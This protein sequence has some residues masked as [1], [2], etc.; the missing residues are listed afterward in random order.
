MSEY[1]ELRKDLF[2]SGYCVDPDDFPAGTDPE[3]FSAIDEGQATAR[4]LI[5][6]KKACET[7]L[8]FDNCSSQSEEIAVELWRRGVGLAV[9]GGEQFAV[10]TSASTS[11]VE[12]P[13]TFTFDL[14]KIPKEPTLA[15]PILRQGWRAG[16]LLVTGAPPQGVKAVRERYLEQLKVAN[17]T[18]FTQ[19]QETLGEEETDRT[20]QFIATAVF[21]QKDFRDFSAKKRKSDKSAK[22]RYDADSFDLEESAELM[23]LFLRETIAIRELGITRPANKAT[24][25]AAD[26]YQKLVTRYKTDAVTWADFNNILTNNRRDPVAALE[27]NSA[28]VVRVREK[29]PGASESYVRAAAR[30]RNGTPSQKAVV[31][32]LVGRYGKT[33]NISTGIIKAVAT[34]TAENAVK[35]I[36]GIVERAEAMRQIFGADHSIIRDGDFMQFARNYRTMQSCLDALTQFVQ[37]VHALSDEY[38]GNPD[39]NYAL[40]RRFSQGSPSAPREA[41]EAYLAALAELRAQGDDSLSDAQLRSA[42][43]QG[44]RSYSEAQKLQQIRLMKDRFKKRISRTGERAVAG[45]VIKHI[46]TL[47]PIDEIEGTT[48]AAYKMINAGYL[49]E[50]RGEAPNL[51]GEVDE[52]LRKIF[53]PQREYVTFTGALGQL[54][55][56]ERIAFATHHGL[57]PLMYGVEVSHETALFMLS[58]PGTLAEYYDS[59][60]GPKCQQLNTENPTDTALAFSVIQEDLRSFKQ[61]GAPTES[62]E[63]EYTSLR[64]IRDATL[65]VGGHALYLYDPGIARSPEDSITDQWLKSKVASI[66][67]P[68]EQAAALVRA[69]EALQSGTIVMAG[70]G[71]DNYRVVFSKAITHSDATD[72]ERAVIANSLGLDRLIFNAD[73]TQALHH[74]L[75][76]QVLTVTIHRHHQPEIVELSDDELAGRAAMELQP[77]I[78]QEWT[79]ITHDPLAFVTD[80]GL[81]I[82]LHDALSADNRSTIAEALLVA[83]SRYMEHPNHRTEVQGYE[84]QVYLAWQCIRGQDPQAAI[85]QFN[86]RP[87]DVSTS[88]QQGMQMIIEIIERI[89]Q[90]QLRPIL[91]LLAPPKPDK[92]TPTRETKQRRPQTGSAT[93]RTT[94]KP[95]T[96]TESTKLAAEHDEPTPENKSKDTE[97]S[98][99]IDALGHYLRRIGKVPL[100]T[101]IEEV[102]LAQTIEAGVFAWERL[103]AGD[104]SLGTREEL[105]KLVRNGS[106]AK[107][108]MIESNLRLVVR[109][110][111]SYPVQGGHMQLSDYIDEGNLGLIRAV[112]K[113][114]YKKGYKFSTYA[115]WWIKQAITRARADQEHTIRIPVHAFDLARKIQRISRQYVVEHGVEPTVEILAQEAN[116]T[117]AQVEMSQTALRQK[118]G[119]LNSPISDDGSAEF[120]D[121]IYDENAAGTED[122]ATYNVD[123]EHLRQE[124][125]KAL[126]TMAIL[127]AQTV[128]LRYGLPEVEGLFDEAFI[129]KHNIV[130]GTRYS[131]DAI[132]AMYDIT[133]QGVIKRDERALRL[134]RKSGIG[135][136][137]AGVFDF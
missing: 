61:H 1:S 48:E 56:A 111:R 25:F 30:S 23:D 36:D 9:V 105:E 22:P 119:S 5:V 33:D 93:P 63:R 35:I 43:K 58:Q 28:T 38:A 69:H 123:A 129:K 136:Q 64:G 45:T 137:F 18:L 21:Q 107:N 50:A 14:T 112:E 96:V 27:R 104:F 19:A 24:L 44:V 95:R 102:E 62:I 17:P 132:A 113:F 114:D 3:V 53:N 89:P 2:P 134:F 10:K 51:L 41:A 94:R 120:G 118:P 20:V 74:R 6:A 124:L 85:D 11:S 84:P 42:A 31:E 135:R 125:A 39:V 46:A 128:V 49:V 116:A 68:H 52:D 80:R 92:S 32:E 66:F 7:C 65:V 78:A 86:I 126:Q 83:F 16:Q 59:V 100:L 133:R 73:L 57:G 91:A 71:P 122:T 106:L 131:M 121:L 12:L 115:T 55:T 82:S 67:P 4:Q 81:K 70:D 98:Y 108:R 26:F 103:Q 97:E 117:I 88:I 90:R 110:A 15:L 130:F 37:N 127:P 47:Y 8:Q 101:A 79:A 29:N 40:I 76:G 54:S 99:K 75:G 60:L 77:V 109:N 72:L 34:S 13:A 87:E